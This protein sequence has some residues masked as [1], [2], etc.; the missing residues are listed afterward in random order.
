[1]V[2]VPVKMHIQNLA[3]IANKASRPFSLL[4]SRQRTAVL[5]VMAEQL[6]GR[7]DDVLA[8]NQEDLDAIPKD[9]GAEEFRK[10]R[11]RVMVTKEDVEQMVE[12]IRRICSE[13][14]P[15][16]QE[17]QGW[18]SVDGLEVSR[19]RVPIG[20][21]GIISEFGP[22]VLAESVAMCVRSA[23]VCIVRGGK[24]C[25]RTN[26]ALMTVLKEAAES[27]GMPIGGITF[28]DRP[29]KDG[30]LELTRLPKLVHGVIPRGRAGLRKVIL[31]Q[32][33]V[34]VLGYDGGLC[35]VYI[36]GAADLP[37]A[38]GVVVNS[39]IQDPLDSNSADT[40]LVH[41]GLSRQLLPG[42][43]RRLLGDFKVDLIG[44]PKT[45]SLMGIMEMTGHKG[46]AEAKE[47]DWSQKS[48]SLKLAVKVVSNLDEAINHI[49]TYSPG[50]TDTIVTR[51]YDTAMRFVR[52]VDSSAVLVNASTRLHAGSELGLGS[53]MGVN[54]N[55]FHVR[56][57]LT[58]QALTMEKVVGLGTGQLR[59]PHPVV[60][61][62]QDAAM[63][64]A[65][66]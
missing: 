48:Q 55:R 12:T 6:E 16:G 9:I 36:D 7:I 2:E 14:D 1:M 26:T 19:V 21:I 57:P 18:M 64:S 10:Q 50:H 63:L 40:L 31:E 20:V 32:S 56:G 4:S 29:D 30:V 43:V 25:F 28:I 49:N 23:N 39:K 61:E 59:H 27:Q 37:L 13:P 66:F 3:R 17:I 51:D 15:I 44:C 34:P 46:I 24:D 5:E 52:E 8:G 54:I 62:Y 53:D 35:H 65:K 42:L 38:Q 58:L 47:E 41:Q 33:R 22:Q 60:S 11:E 45:V